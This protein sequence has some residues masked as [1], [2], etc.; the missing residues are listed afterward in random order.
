M[1]L[2]MPFAIGVSVFALALTGCGES[3]SASEEDDAVDE[4]EVVSSLQ[5]YFQTDAAPTARF[6]PGYLYRIDISKANAGKRYATIYVVTDA[7]GQQSADGTC[8]RKWVDTNAKSLDR[9][10]NDLTVSTRKKKISI[11]YEVEENGDYVEKKHEWT[12]KA[13]ASGLTLTST[14]SNSYPFDVKRMPSKKIDAGIKT[15][16]N[17]W[18]ENELA[19]D[20]SIL[21]DAPS[22]RTQDLPLE[23]QRC[24][25]YYDV[26]WS[27]YGTD[28]RKI[29]VGGKYYYSLSQ[30][31]DGGGKYVF[32]SLDGLE[33][34]EYGGSESGEWDLEFDER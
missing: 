32:F 31:N 17:S 7:C 23:A 3:G 13:S 8:D 1:N 22:V 18:F 24:V 5:G 27:D 14:A 2:R 21:D 4:S 25:H 28:A 33:I 16:F 6:R 19:D 10:W 34:G 26:E 15:A 12:Y 30:Q 11:S 9:R 29:K 20:S